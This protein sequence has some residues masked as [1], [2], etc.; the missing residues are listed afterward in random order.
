MKRLEFFTY[1]G[2]QML[3]IDFSHLQATEVLALITEAK[4]VVAQQPQQSLLTLT[5]VTQIGFNKEV[6]AALQEYA[7]HNK[8]Y[9]KAAAIVGITEL[10]KNVEE[11]IQKASAR[12]LK[13]FATRE[14]AQAWLRQQ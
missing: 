7:L 10:L 11:S 14:E 13:N 4:Q 6:I 12:Q 8:P 1:Q 2:K 5:D 3:L 9:V